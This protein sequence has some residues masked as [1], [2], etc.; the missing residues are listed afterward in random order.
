MRMGK[1][2][3]R[4]AYRSEAGFTIME[5]LVVV[6]IVALLAA[7]SMP[8]LKSY[9]PRYTLR[10]AARDTMNMLQRAKMSAVRDN[11]CWRLKIDPDANT[12]TLV[13]Y[14]CVDTEGAAAQVLDLSTLGYR[15]RFVPAAQTTC[16]KAEKNW[17]GDPISQT[18][19]VT[20]TARG[21]ANNRSIFIEN[22]NKDICFAV[23]ATMA[24]SIRLHRYNGET[25]FATANWD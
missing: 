17:N 22:V 24:G 6:G 1:Q 4:S 21:F 23:T 13:P 8:A 20:F 5:L 16:G 15:T 14:N 2:P 12:G 18:D 9:M 3:N 7:A 10:G 19:L 11:S 25:P